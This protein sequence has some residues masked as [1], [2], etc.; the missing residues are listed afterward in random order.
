MIAAKKI[1][2]KTLHFKSGG[3][4]FNHSMG[5]PMKLCTRAPT[6]IAMPL[7]LNITSDIVSVGVVYL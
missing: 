6:N 5:P 7:V 3:Y 4:V 1:P 2:K